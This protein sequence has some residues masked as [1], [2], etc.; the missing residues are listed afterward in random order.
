MENVAVIVPAW[1]E[2]RDIQQ[3]LDTLG[4]IEWLAEIVVV[5]DGSS[6]E[7]LQVAL[8]CA[9]NYPR[10]KILGLPVNQGKERE[11]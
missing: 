1:N 4:P 7:T 5:D 10:M 2:E 11:E 3:V 6:D 9:T 8:E